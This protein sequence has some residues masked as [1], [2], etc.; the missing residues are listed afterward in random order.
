[1][2]PSYIGLVPFVEFYHYIAISFQLKLWTASPSPL[3]CSEHIN[4]TCDRVYHHIDQEELIGTDSYFSLFESLFAPL[5][6]SF[7]S[8]SSLLS[9]GEKNRFFKGLD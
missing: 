2:A 3:E 4:L 7:L 6:G 1:L 8:P 9:I 5:I